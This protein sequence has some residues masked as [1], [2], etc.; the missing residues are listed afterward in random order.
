MAIHRILLAATCLTALSTPLRAQTCMGGATFAHRRAQMN[1]DFSSRGSAA[2]AAETGASLGAT[3]GPFLTLGVGLAHDN[4]LRGNATALD[5]TAGL[6]F[7]VLSHPE[8]ELCPF[9]AFATLNGVDLPG[10]RIASLSYGIGL[11]LGTR[12]SSDSGFAVVPFVGGA[13]LLNSSTVSFGHAEATG[14]DNFFNGSVGV[15]FVI[16]DVFTIRPSASY[17]IAHGQT[18]SSFALRFSYSF[19][20]VP[21]HIRPAAGD[22]S[23]SSVWVNPREM[24]YYCSGSRWY[25]GTAEGSFMT[26]REAIA[27]GFGAEHGKRC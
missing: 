12:L 1:G 18:T 21:P 16:Q 15:G 25:G 20:I 6:G 17:V 10:E 2:Y 3:P 4:N 9:F 23:M 14:V 27:A 24:I 8:T 11:G 5:G 26:E 19:G 13:F 7:P 22:G